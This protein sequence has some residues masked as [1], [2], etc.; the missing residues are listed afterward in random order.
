MR[1]GAAAVYGFFLGL[2]ADS[3]TVNAFGAAAL[4]MSIVGF[5]ASWLKAVF[6]ADNLALN[7]F[8]L[9]LAKWVFDLIFLSRRAPRRTV[10][11]SRCRSSSGRRLAAA[12]GA[13]RRDRAVVVE[14][15]D[16]SANGVSFHPNDI[17]RRG[18][19][20]SIIVCGVLVF[21]LSAFFRAQVLRNQQ[22]LLQS[23]ENRLRQIPT[24][25]PRGVILDR[26]NKPIAENVVGYSVAL[27]AQNEDTLR[28]DAHA[29]ARHDQADEQAVSGRDQ[30]VPPRP[31][32]PHRDRAGRV[33]RRRIGARGTSDRFSGAHHPVRAQAHLSR[34]R[35][36]GCLR[37]VRRRNQRDELAS[38]SSQGYKPGQL[39]GKQG[40]EKQ[41]EQQLRGREGMQFVEVDARNRIVPNGQA[42]EAGDAAGRPAALHQHRHRSPGVHPPSVRRHAVRGGG[43]DGSADGRSARAVQLPGDRSESFR[44]RACRSR[45]TIL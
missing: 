18:R 22:S 37:R 36:R 33:V 28:A 40:L 16:G 2:M 8:F 26:N 34:R 38:M 5:G 17:V 44:R 21:L 6:F 31:H 9:F 10:P 4:G 19:A 23:E 29:A 11:S 1:P 24:A 27:L 42:R 25:A 3:L 30:A 20:A 14:T 35:G 45:I 41:Y 15:A 12:D 32:A 7:G 39:V 43:G 13:G